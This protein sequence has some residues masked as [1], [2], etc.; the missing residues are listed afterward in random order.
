MRGLQVVLGASGGI[1]NALVHE[2]V[3]RG[4]EVRGESRR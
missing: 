1:G 2:L 4:L 3:R